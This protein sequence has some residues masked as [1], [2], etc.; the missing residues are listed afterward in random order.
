MYELATVL[1]DEEHEQVLTSVDSYLESIEYDK[2]TIAQTAMGLV[3]SLASKTARQKSLA[4]QNALTRVWNT[5]LGKNQK[6]SASIIEDEKKISV[7]SLFLLQ[8]MSERNY[9]GFELIAT[10]S[11][12]LNMIAA[13]N[14]ESMQ[15]LS[16]DMNEFIELTTKVFNS[17]KIK[18]IELDK[19]VEK[20]EQNVQ[21]LKW[22]NTI[23]Y[24]AYQGV[25]YKE[26]SIATRL[27]CLLTDFL[28]IMG[29]GWDLY[30]LLL[31]KGAFAEVGI[32]NNSPITYN[33]IFSCLINSPMLCMALLDAMQYEPKQN[34][35]NLADYDIP[36]VS[37]LL[38]IEKLQS[39]EKM[40]IETVM[41]LTGRSFNEVAETVIRK[42]VVD[43]LG[44]NPLLTLKPFDFILESL[45][46]RRLLLDQDEEILT[47]DSVKKEYESEQFDSVFPKLLQLEKQTHSAEI[48]FMIGACYDYGQG[49][50]LN[51]AKA[52]EWYRLAAH[53]REGESEGDANAQLGLGYC[54][55]N[56]DGVDE[57]EAEAF[58]WFLLSAEQG[59]A[60][61]QSNIGWFY[62]DGKYV[63][64]D[65]TEAAKWYLKAAEQDHSVAQNNIGCLYQVGFGVVQDYSKAVKWYQKAAQ[66]ENS[67]AQ[68]WL[69]LLY[70]EGHG[71]SQ[72]FAEAA[73]W[74][75]KAAEQGD[76]D[77]QFSLSMFYNEGHG[78]SQDYA[79][80]AKW[81]QKAAEQEHSSAQCWLGL[82]YEKGRGVSQD[83]AEAAKWYQK[84]AEQG[85]AAAQFFLGWL[86]HEGHGVSQD[87]S[88][89]VKWFHKAA[90]QERSDA[91]FWMGLSYEKGRGVSQDYTEA[92]KWYQ[93]A[94]EQRDENAQLALG[95]LYQEGYGISQDF[96][97]SLKWF[98]KAAEQG[99]S[100]A[101]NNLGWIYEEGRGVLQ[102]YSEAAKWYQKA[103]EQ[104]VKEA[105]CSLGCL[106]DEGNGVI[107]DYSKAAKWYRMAANQGH[108]KSQVCL[109]AMLRDGKG[110]NKN[111]VQ[112][113]HLFRLAAENGNS[114][115]AYCL[116]QLYEKG[117]GV[118]LNKEEAK[119]WYSRAAELGDGDATEEFNRL[120]K[121][122]GQKI[123][124]A[125][126]TTL[127][128]TGAVAAGVTGLML[129]EPHI[130][131]IETAIGDKYT[132]DSY[133]LDQVGQYHYQGNVN[134]TKK[135][136]WGTQGFFKV[137]ASS[138]S[139]MYLTWNV[140]I[141]EFHRG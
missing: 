81:C 133:Q 79:E 45:Q 42:Y 48:Q 95:F 77:A 137:D 110:I 64:Q 111:S 8:K 140:S 101:Q 112:A 51:Y 11:N 56:G 70:Q 73:K 82:F 100:M 55:L 80:A 126:G 58:K 33:D 86:Y 84:A 17:A 9:M 19:R 122:T 94:A 43:S 27:L 34:C 13:M 119:K 52:I 12:R 125:V 105:Q 134:V 32:Q 35:S 46:N 3:N 25:L 59:N 67:V 83:Y 92:V 6:L 90:K 7:A 88:E 103:A 76:E 124:S 20:L 128:V 37:I 71:V 99:S 31:M 106:F 47:F 57:S 49:V 109:G 29:K 44:I 16:S 26:L 30:D 60:D 41:E 129:G 85:D 65:Y 4:T 139:G 97:E 136:L 96:T 69:G 39:S 135:G 120:N 132:I 54:Y 113:A 28:R 68:F 130:L 98:K 104:G 102:D 22:K 18:I 89:A 87:Y 62:R 5:I 114:T 21:L 50:Q 107:Q 63:T 24:Q 38:K 141:S 36:L 1:R 91:Q 23:E 40:N 123:F 14:T 138:N 115:G 15:E 117:D 66:Q 108:A 127:A 53:P 131:A 72:D 93:K 121:T 118:S 75:Q 2:V 74:Y 61:A 78:V 116:A 10:L